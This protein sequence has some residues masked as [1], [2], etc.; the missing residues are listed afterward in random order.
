MGTV[1]IPGMFWVALIVFV[2][3]WLPELVPDVP[4]LPTALLVLSALLK[5]IE[6]V[7][8]QHDQRMIGTMT[9]GR[10]FGRWLIG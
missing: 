2:I 5:A 3:K 4:W 8:Q 9:L 10:W 6:V 7:V 1:R